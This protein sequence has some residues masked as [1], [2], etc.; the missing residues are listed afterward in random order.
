MVRK[1]LVVH[2]STP[3]QPKTLI[4]IC[5]LTICSTNTHVRFTKSE[6]IQPAANKRKMLSQNQ[7]EFKQPTNIY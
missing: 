1:L 7:Q 6:P 4:N 2:A 3:P 5:I